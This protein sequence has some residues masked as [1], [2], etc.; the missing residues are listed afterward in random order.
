MTITGDP[1]A[2]ALDRAPSGTVFC[3]RDVITPA[4]RRH[5]EF[6]ND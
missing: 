5:S 4:L 3:G 1:V 6:Y 2:A